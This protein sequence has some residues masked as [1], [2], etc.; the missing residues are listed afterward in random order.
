MKLSFLGIKSR[1]LCTSSS[2]EQFVH[3]GS[4]EIFSASVVKSWWMLN[5]SVMTVMC[6]T[7]CCEYASF[8]AIWRRSSMTH[9]LICL[10]RRPP[11]TQCS[12][13]YASTRP[14]TSE[15]DAVNSLNWS[16]DPRFL[17]VTENWKKVWE[18]HWLEARGSK[19]NK[20]MDRNEGIKI[21]DKSVEIKYI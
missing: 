1:T 16:C 8:S 18:F 6:R 21:P 20:K 13:S 11:L 9:G 15:Y 4:N 17:Q 14:K 7:W 12:A 19:N 2:P 5:I 10:H 3:R